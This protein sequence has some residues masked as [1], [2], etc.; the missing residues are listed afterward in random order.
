MSVVVSGSCFLFLWGSDEFVCVSSESASVL[1]S[2]DSSALLLEST[3]SLP[4]EPARVHTNITVKP[5]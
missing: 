2:S 5:V 1:D 3:F 4:S